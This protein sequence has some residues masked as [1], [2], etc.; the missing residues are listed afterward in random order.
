MKKFI[1]IMALLPLVAA[2]LYAQNSTPA[3]WE[4]RRNLTI[5]EWNTD[6]RTKT[7]WL[8][9]QTT[10]D[11]EGRK[12]EEIEYTQYG[13]KW[14]ETYEYGDNDKIVKE[15]LYDEKDRPELIRR[16]EYNAQNKKIRQ[17]NYAPSGRL[18]TI[19]VFEYIIEEQ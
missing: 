9:H 12:T 5:K 17:Y 6:Q 1:L 11:S 13:Q 18:L 2:S 10:Y 19:K 8:D 15:V 7:R 14:R 16:Y 3:K 4:E